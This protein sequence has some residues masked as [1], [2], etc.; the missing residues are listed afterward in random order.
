MLVY[1]GKPIVSLLELGLELSDV[2]VELGV[3][4]VLGV[5]LVRVHAAVSLLS[6]ADLLHRDLLGALSVCIGHH[7]LLVHIVHL[8]LQILPFTGL[9]AIQVTGFRPLSK[10]LL[11]LRILNCFHLLFDL[12]V[13]LGRDLKVVNHFLLLCFFDH[14]LDFAL[15]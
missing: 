9:L 6:C 13:A 1:P 5:R 3:D 4:R 8:L 2:L 15:F 14:E 11:D 7:N 10:L 12:V